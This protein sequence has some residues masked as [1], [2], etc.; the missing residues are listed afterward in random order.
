MKIRKIEVLLAVIL[1]L[2][3]ALAFLIMHKKKVSTPHG[4][5]R[6]TVGGDLYG[7]YSLGKD[8]D[9]KINDHNTLRILDGQARMVEATCPDH[10]CISQSPID[11]RGGMI[12]CL[13]NQVFVEGIP[14]KSS[15]EDT[16]L[17]VDAVAN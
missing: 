9:I 1:V 11:D 15:E 8:Q 4:S 12:I 10:I 3:S 7:E 5:I 13:P 14:L 2:G 6:I 17:K 16:D